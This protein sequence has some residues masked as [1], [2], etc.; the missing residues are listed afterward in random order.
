M[1]FRRD[2]W[3][4]SPVSST[5]PAFDSSFAAASVASALESTTLGR[6][7]QG[8]APRVVRVASITSDDYQVAF[9]TS[10]IVVS[11][12]EGIQCLG[13]TVETFMVQPTWSHIAMISS[14]DVTVNVSIGY[15]G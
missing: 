9:G 11:S 1:P 6:V 15:G 2:Q 3:L 12:S 8:P 5:S 10:D 14:T 4:Y 7:W 13:G